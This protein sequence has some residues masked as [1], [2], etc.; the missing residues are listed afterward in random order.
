[1]QAIKFKF[2][3]LV[4]CETFRSSKYSV[5]ILIQIKILDEGF[6]KIC[7][8]SAKSNVKM[9]GKRLKDSCKEKNYLK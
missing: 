1:M 6:W 9:R 3:I 8:G 7:K 4:R 2:S 5:L